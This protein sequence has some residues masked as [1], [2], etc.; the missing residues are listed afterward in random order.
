[1]IAGG[2]G[3]RAH[4]L[5]GQIRVADLLPDLPVGQAAVFH[6]SAHSLGKIA[7]DIDGG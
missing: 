2:I 1:M 4:G 3:Q 5:K 6:G 7:V